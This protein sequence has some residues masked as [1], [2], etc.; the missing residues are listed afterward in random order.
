LANEVYLLG[1]QWSLLKEIKVKEHNHIEALAEVPVDSPWFSGHFPGE[2]IL[3]GI[4]LVHI[5]EQAIIEFAKTKGE[6]F[7]LHVLKRVRFTQP[8]RPGETL[9]VKITGEE[10]DNE[11]FFTFKVANKKDIVCSGLIAVQKKKE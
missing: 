5:V 1:S 9:T 6:R 10:T 8:V 3:P 2:P 11:V 4:A 7:H